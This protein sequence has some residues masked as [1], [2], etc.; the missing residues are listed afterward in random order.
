MFFCGD[1]R[2]KDGGTGESSFRCGVTMGTSG[3]TADMDSSVTSF[4]TSMTE[5]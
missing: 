1:L 3:L 4:N 5:M 2:G